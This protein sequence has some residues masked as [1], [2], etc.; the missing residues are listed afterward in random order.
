[1]ECMGRLAGLLLC[2]VCLTIVPAKSMLRLC[3]ERQKNVAE[4]RAKRFY[5][6]LLREGSLTK[7]A[8]GQWKELMG[9]IDGVER[10]ELMFARRYVMPAGEKGGASP[11]LP[12]KILYRADLE[13]MFLET[14][15]FV[16]DGS[17]FVSISIYGRNGLLY[18]C[19]G[20]V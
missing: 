9:E 20:E 16:L 15:K 2:I 13:E 8:Y 10:F 5:A 12:M 1:M 7:E 4:V 18:S 3:D 19:G 11:G 14:D 6:G 17:I